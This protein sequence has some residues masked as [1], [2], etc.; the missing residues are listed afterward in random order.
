M[1]GIRPWQS[2]YHLRQLIFTYTTHQF[3]RL[4]NRCLDVKNFKMAALSCRSIFNSCFLLRPMQ[5]CLVT[6][7]ATDQDVKKE[8]KRKKMEARKEM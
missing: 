5:R 6:K 2:G 3:F 1:C 4:G 8:K 7:L